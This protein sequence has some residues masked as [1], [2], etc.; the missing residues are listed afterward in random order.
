[1]NDIF[2]ALFRKVAYVAIL[3][4]MYWVFDRT[5]LGNFD[6]AEAIKDDPKAIAHLLGMLALAGAL[7]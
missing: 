6:T 3:L 7:S 2:V 4:L 5:F 1:V